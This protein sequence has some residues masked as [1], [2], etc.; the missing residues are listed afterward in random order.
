VAS[1]RLAQDGTTYEHAREASASQKVIIYR[2]YLTP[3]KK[4]KKE[5]AYCHYSKFVFYCIPFQTEATTIGKL[6]QSTGESH[7]QMPI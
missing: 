6:L 5:W 1:L 2:L 4:W 3:E 7:T